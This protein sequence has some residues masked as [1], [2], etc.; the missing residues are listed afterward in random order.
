MDRIKVKF[1]ENWN[2]AIN[3]KKVKGNSI[4]KALSDYIDSLDNPQEMSFVLNL[5]VAFS[6]GVGVFELQTCYATSDFT[7][8]FIKE[9][10]QQV[11]D[12]KIK[13]EIFKNID[14]PQFNPETDISINNNLIIKSYIINFKKKCK[15]FSFN[16]LIEYFKETEILNNFK[17]IF[18][19][20]ESSNIKIKS[21]EEENFMY[22]GVMFFDCDKSKN[23]IEDF[24]TFLNLH[25]IV[26]TKISNS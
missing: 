8:P 20:S 21:Q 13:L 23:Y 26:L 19:N 1:K 18:F 17:R 5:L 24:K 16:E 10:E 4:V 11:F 15:K 9:V 22:K 12:K 25:N 14:F 3:R 7:L 6:S 2:I